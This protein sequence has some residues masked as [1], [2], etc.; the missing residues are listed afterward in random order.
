MVHA[1]IPKAARSLAKTIVSA[2]TPPLLAAYAACPLCPSNAATLAVL[3]NT[4]EYILPRY[5]SRDKGIVATETKT[6]NF[7]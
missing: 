2:R 3:I 6:C 1:L 7:V 4:P 5:H